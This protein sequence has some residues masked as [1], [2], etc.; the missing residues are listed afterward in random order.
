[1]HRT[2]WR[3]VPDF[4][5][6]VFTIPLSLGAVQKVIQRGS[7]ALVPHHEAM[8]TLAHQ[9]PVGYID[10]TPWYC[11]NALQWLWIMAT[12]MVAYSRMD[13]HRSKEAFV[14]FIDDWQGL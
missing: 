3:L 6:S 7:Q 13:P 4:C 14:A 8:A 2:S 12:D 1:M 10:E 5:P 9:A 11:H